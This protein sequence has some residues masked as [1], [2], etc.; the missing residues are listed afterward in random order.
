M[1]AACL[2]KYSPVFTA[3]E[4]RE[5]KKPNLSS[6]QVLIVVEAFGLNFANVMDRLGLYKLLN[7]NRT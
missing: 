7:Y 4:I 1:R 6:D 3:F 2:L 5:Y